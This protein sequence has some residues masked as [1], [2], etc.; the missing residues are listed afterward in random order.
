VFTTGEQD[1]Y[2]KKGFANEPSRCPECRKADTRN[3]EAEYSGGYDS[4]ESPPRTQE[5]FAAACAQCG[6]DTQVSARVLFGDEPICC[7]ECL[8]TQPVSAY[9]ATGGWRDSW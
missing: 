5:L 9:A 4:P 7:A 2:A 6:K 8:A 3:R 1:F